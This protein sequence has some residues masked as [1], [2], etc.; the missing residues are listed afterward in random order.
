[1]LLGTFIVIHLLL[2]RHHSVQVDRCT[3]EKGLLLLLVVIINWFILLHC[4]SRFA[5]GYGRLR[6]WLMHY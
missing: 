5:D 3:S 1:M 4:A 6:G 2:P